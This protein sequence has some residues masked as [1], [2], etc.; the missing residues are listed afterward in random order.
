MLDGNGTDIR[1][2]TKDVKLPVRAAWRAA[3]F[4]AART[5]EPPGMGCGPDQA[6]ICRGFRKLGGGKKDKI[7]TRRSLRY[8]TSKFTSADPGG[9][10]R[11]TS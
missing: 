1:T 3:R 9:D 6:G 7:F 11:F 4:T 10:V 2:G 5:Q 8:T